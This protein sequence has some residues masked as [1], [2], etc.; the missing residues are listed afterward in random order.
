MIHNTLII[1]LYAYIYI[2]EEYLHNYIYYQLTLKI[3]V[4]INLWNWALVVQDSQ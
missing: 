3:N 1:N 4:K 2:P